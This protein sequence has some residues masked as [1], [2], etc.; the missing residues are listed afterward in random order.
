[1]FLC[2]C[3]LQLTSPFTK[4]YLCSMLLA[5][6]IQNNLLYL[7]SPCPNMGLFKL[8]WWLCS[9]V[10][11]LG[12]N[13]EPTVLAKTTLTRKK[14]RQRCNRAEKTTVM[15][16]K[17]T[18]AV[19]WRCRSQSTHHLSLQP[20]QYLWQGHFSLLCLACPNTSWPSLFI[21]TGTI[22]VLMSPHHSKIVK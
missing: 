2:M 16:T 5:P 11:K 1:M 6:R 17:R 10:F 3:I 7:D 20:K 14:S 19:V 4:E 21:Y 18:I 9:T 8:S 12:S 13:P 15:H 22:P